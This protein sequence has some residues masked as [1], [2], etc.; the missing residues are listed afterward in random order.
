MDLKRIRVF[1]S[2]MNVTT[3]YA[4]RHINNSINKDGKKS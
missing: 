1:L 4:P 3:K 2:I